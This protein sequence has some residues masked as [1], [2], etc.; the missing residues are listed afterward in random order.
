MPIVVI[1]SRL[2]EEWSR[3]TRRIGADDYLTK[4]F[5]TAELLEKVAK[6]MEI[7]HAQTV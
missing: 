4:G 2:A 3:E 1:S 6:Y 5:S 7:P